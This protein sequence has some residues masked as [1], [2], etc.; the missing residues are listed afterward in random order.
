MATIAPPPKP[1]NPVLLD[2]EQY[3]DDQIQRT[4]RALKFVDFMAG[5]L[6]LAIGVLAFIFVSAVLDQWIIP[7]GLGAFGRGALF[8]VLLVGAAWYGWRQFIPLLRSINPVYAAHTIE[9]GTPSLK[10][11]LLNLLLFRTHRREVSTRV[12]HA[13]E[14]QAA[15]R[16]S[17]SDIEVAIDRSALLRL[18]YL[19]LFIVAACAI[20]AVLSPKN[21]AVS[22]VRVLAPWSDV[23]PPSRVQILDI[24]PGETSVAKGQRLPVS[25]EIHGLK[26]DET[27]RLRYSTAD[28]QLI[29]ESLPMKLPT[30]GGRRYE[31]QLPRGGEGAVESGVQQDLIYW[32]EAGDARSK[33]FKATVYSRPTIV[34]QKV[35]YEYPAYT[36]LPT[37]E[38]ENTGDIRGLEGTKVTISALANQPIKTAFVDFDAD[39]GNDLRMSVDG[40]R[41]TA[42]FELGLRKDRR[43]PTHVSYLLRFTTTEG[44]S[45]VDPPKYRIDVTPDYAPEIRITAPEE[46]EKTVRVDEIVS[47][48]VEARDPDYA[49]EQVRLVGKAG[50]REIELASLLG[51]KREGLFRALHPM[52]PGDVQ[53]KPGE[54]LEY[55]AEAQDNRRPEGNLA[56]SEH[57]R[58]KIAGPANQQ[59]QQNGQNQGQ[60]GGQGQNGDQNQDQNQNGQG[61]EKNQGGGQQQG[62]QAGDKNNNGEKADGQQT[63]GGSAGNDGQGDKSEGQQNGGENAS[64]Q[65]QQDNKQPNNQQQGGGAPGGQGNNQ[66][67][68]QG[69]S[70]QAQPQQGNGANGAQPQPGSEQQSQSKPQPGDSPEGQQGQSQN[71]GDQ[72]GQPS[73]DQ[74]QNDNA[75]QSAQAQD[76]RSQG[77]QPQKGE[78]QGAESQNGQKGEQQSK[79]SS[80]GDADADAIKRMLDHLK[81]QESKS[82]SNSSTDS[83]P[84]GEPASAGGPRETAQAGEQS[85]QQESNAQQGDSSNQQETGNNQDSAKAGKESNQQSD[86]ESNQ[87]HG[88]QPKSADADE[89]STA[90]PNSQDAQGNQ[91]P[92][93]KPSN[94][95]DPAN[96]QLQGSTSQEKQ[97]T[98]QGNQSGQPQG[99]HNSSEANGQGGNEQQ[100]AEKPSANGAMD[101]NNRNPG[102]G[103]DSKDKEGAPLDPSA[104]KQTRDKTPGDNRAGQN[105]QESPTPAENN[106]ESNS[107]GDQN[108]AQAGGGTKGAGQQAQ[109]KGKGDPGKNE[110]A[111]D[112]AGHANEQGQGET[113]SKAGKDQLAPGKTGESSKN[114]P[115]AGSKEGESGQPGSTA[116]GDDS[117]SAAGDDGKEQ[118]G[119]NL[120]A[121]QTQPDASKGAKPDA[122]KAGEQPETGE[123]GSQSSTAQPNN[124]Q[125]SKQ[126]GKPGSTGAMQPQGGGQ[127]GPLDASAQPPESEAAKE[128]KANL[129]FARKQTDLVLERLDSQ[130]AKKQVD[131]GLLK[132]LGWTEDDL[133]QFI[134]RWKGLK[135]KAE[136]DKDGN[137]SRELDAALRS[138]GLRE[139]G[140]NR[141]KGSAKADQLRDLKD[142]YR[143]RAPLEYAERVRQYNK[144]VA[145]Q[146]DK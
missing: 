124:Q 62:G 55:W 81:Q 83:N 96:N 73:P 138:L 23:P 53:L 120:S 9:R 137:A 24:K 97:G 14:Q 47:F 85:S 118:Q 49:L 82:Q 145:S 70:P 131:P 15:L 98:Q 42:S 33:R 119:K 140:P 88:D 128:D 71:A 25:A 111:D 121:P 92:Q 117:K 11:S 50:N 58:L 112:G 6:T 27:V 43:I 132:S 26:P 19:L 74:K 143:S 104:A 139:Q 34:V 68:K 125:A 106:R 60:P 76:G 108:G 38:A 94:N 67:Q 113:G 134:G 7:G 59:Q 87:Q 69:Q 22:A 54:V 65:S 109:A 21:M 36:G 61:G 101:H 89:Q 146:S 29:D 107:Q 141:I 63:A 102:A 116:E 79:V 46:P 66:D 72:G 31:G 8:G 13:L 44:R 48:G 56:F 114:Q 142:A 10:N 3:I 45:N 105:E 39:G 2:S 135:A 78:P 17:T 51:D 52:T 4:R 20:Y 127:G 100:N 93:Q 144:D 5:L 37:K 86:K 136:S 84:S 77:G 64:G 41:A 35:L 80:K 18:G 95:S 99:D 32:I 16:L 12:Y 91:A 1:V 115:G 110:A 103:Q 28:Q 122:Q 57:R 130:L 123:Q 40:D 30:E 126:Q 129:D 90:K 75:A 133:R